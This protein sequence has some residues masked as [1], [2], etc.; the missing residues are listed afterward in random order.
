MPRLSRHA[1]PASPCPTPAA[2]RRLAVGCFVLRAAA[3]GRGSSSPTRRSTSTSIRRGFLGDVASAWSPTER[4]RPRLGGPVRRLPVPDGAVVRR[5]ATRSASRRGSCTGCGSARCCRSRRGAWCGCWTS[6]WARDRGVAHVGGGG[7]VR[8]QPVRHG[9]REP[10]VGGAAGL[11][12]AAVAA[13][14]RAPRPAR[15]AAAGAGPPRS[16]S[17]SPATGGGVNVA[18]T[19]WVLRRARCCCSLYEPALGRRRARA[20]SC[21]SAGGWRSRCA[22]ASAWWVVPVLVHAHYG[23]ELPA[24]HRAAGHDLGDDVGQRVAAADGLLDELHRRRLR[25]DAAAVRRARHVLLFSP[26]VVVRGPAR[27]GAGRSAASPGRAAGAT[28]RSSWR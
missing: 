19:G 4:P 17:S 26:T 22:V 20:R 16:R 25:R 10:H 6:L 21:R 28:A 13:A 12:R 9:L 5:S 23:T 8:R 15:P 3:S 1:S 7:P 27:P 14:V 24:V 18:V 11:R 2:A